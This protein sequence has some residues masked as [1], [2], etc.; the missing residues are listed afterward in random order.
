[1]EQILL[2]PAAYSELQELRADVKEIKEALIFQNQKKNPETLLEAR[3]VMKELRFKSYATLWRWEKAGRIK[4]VNP[5]GRPKYRK[6]DVEKIIQ[7]EFGTSS[8]E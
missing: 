7:S 2:S 3:E 6:S 5:E 8:P 4:R 1:M